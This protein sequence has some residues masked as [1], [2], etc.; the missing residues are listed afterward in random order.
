MPPVPRTSSHTATHRP[1]WGRLTVWT[2]VTLSLIAGTALLNW[3]AFVPQPAA[4][5]DP[6][7]VG[8]F[9]EGLAPARSGLVWG[10]VNPELE[11]VIEPRYAGIRHFS[12]G[13]AAVFFGNGWGYIDRLGRTRIEARYQYAGEFRNG[14]ATVALADLRLVEIDGS[15]SV[16][17]VVAPAPYAVCSA[18]DY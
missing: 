12:E 5:G 8:P 14:M 15:G 9:S 17:R 11:W 4:Y 6:Q 2:A 1:D 18:E 13:L 3:P 10:F 16:R 7:E